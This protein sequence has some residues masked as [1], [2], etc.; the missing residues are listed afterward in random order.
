MHFP[1]AGNHVQSRGALQE[2]FIMTIAYL[3]NKQGNYKPVKIPAYIRSILE[4]VHNVGDY[5]Y[6]LNGVNP[7][8]P[9][10][11]IEADL[12]QLETWAKR[13]FADFKIKHINTS[14]KNYYGIFE[15]TDPVAHQLEKVGILK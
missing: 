13:Y 7:I 2:G 14:P 1:G 10:Y 3:P 4:N 11:G 5:T 15:M 6:C 9:G 8:R 12:K